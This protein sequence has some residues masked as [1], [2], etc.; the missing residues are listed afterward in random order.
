[1]VDE[2]I[3]HCSLFL[4]CSG[5]A[6]LVTSSN[7]DRFKNYSLVQYVRQG[8]ERGRKSE[9][10]RFF[11]NSLSLSYHFQS[12]NLQKNKKIFSEIALSKEF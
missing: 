7:V 1:M 4:Y 10:E 9:I 12:K 8:A 6:I 5:K 11:F 2:R 3:T